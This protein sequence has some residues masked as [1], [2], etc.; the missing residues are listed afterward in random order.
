MVGQILPVSENQYQVL[1]QLLDAVGSQRIIMAKQFSVSK[2]LLR[3]LAH[4]ISDSIYEALTGV[5]G[6][7]STRIAYVLVKR[8]PGLATR[9][10]L[11][12]ADADGHNPHTL[13][14]S[15]EPIMSPAWS[16][17]GD[18]LAYVSFEDK[19]A[20]IYIVDVATGR[21]QAVSSFSGINGAPAWS[22]D[23]TQLAVVLS[24]KSH[25]NLYLLDIATKRLKRLTHG[26]SITTEPSWAPD[27]KSLIFTSD[28]GGGPQIYRLQL[29]SA[30]IERLTYVGRYNARG[31]FTSDGEHIVFQHRENGMFN[32]AV[33]DLATG[34]MRI[35]THAGHDES[36]SLAPNDRMLIYATQYTGMGVL[37]VVSLDGKIHWRLPSREG[38]VQ[39]PVWSPFTV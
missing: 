17:G 36:P 34:R 10:V 8:T 33:L 14:K 39:E 20:K 3:P 37:S 11:E 12:V 26:R 16:P 6:I 15:T 5:R 25:P 9:Y 24:R 31:S 29:G 21:R 35:L 7:F 32:I 13:L 30:R 23:G 4:R 1:F 2:A 18:R 27:G 22:P 28:R 38:I 19:R